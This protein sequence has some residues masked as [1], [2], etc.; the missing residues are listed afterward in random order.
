MKQPLLF[1]AV[2]ITFLTLLPSCVSPFS[3]L[4]SARLVGKNNVELTPAYTTTSATSDGET[5]GIQNHVALHAAFGLSSKVDLRMRY[6]YL[7]TKDDD[8]GNGISVIGF[9]PKVS[10]LENRIALSLPIG[11]AFGDEITDTWEF[12]PSVLFTLPAIPD[13]LDITFAPKYILTFCED[14]D[15]LMAFNLGLAISNNVSSWAIRPEYGLLYD[16]GESGHASQFSIG[17]SKTFG[18][19]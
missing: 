3:E 5:D 12:Q 11:T 9:G 17:I 15:D 14:C 1:I 6:E 8:F 10:L 2:S 7:W 13:K 18:K 16:I 4:Q 19:K